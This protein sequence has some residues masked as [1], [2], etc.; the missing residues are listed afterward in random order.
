MN[1]HFEDA[2]KSAFGHFPS[3]VGAP[4]IEKFARLIVDKVEQ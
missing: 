2:Y 3:P 1:R 4:E